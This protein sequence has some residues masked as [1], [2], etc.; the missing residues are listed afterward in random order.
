MSFSIGEVLS[1]AASIFGSRFVSL[2]GMSLVYAVLILVLSIVP[3]AM[4]G[5]GTMLSGETLD[6]GAL[7]PG[8]I[9]VGLLFYLFQFYV[10]GAQ[11]ASLA[12]LASG[13]T[14]GSFGEAFGTGL[15][16]GLS[17]LGSFVLLFIGYIAMAMVIGL[18]FGVLSL[19]GDAGGIL[20]VLMIVALVL[21]IFSKL[22]MMFPIV[23]VDG[24]RN[25]IKI[26]TRSW[27]LTS[28]HL[29][30]II[31]VLV[32]VAIVSIV[33]FGLIALVAA[34]IF[35]AGFAGS[36][37][38]LNPADMIGDMMGMLVGLVL[39]FFV[40]TAVYYAF[41][42]SVF[43]AIHEKISIDTQDIVETFG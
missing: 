16:G 11:M 18:A 29:L 25:V 33:V 6:P 38:A 20:G 26:I 41:T 2:I 22:S 7:G 12:N 39:V 3:F 30:S 1:R 43:A 19:M 13:L 42:A 15:K 14:D 36:A 23:G 17:L 9:G 28:G 5:G 40:V 21:F 24:E 37:E 4:M 34:G 35:G 8:L 31:A 32:I 10:T 27:S